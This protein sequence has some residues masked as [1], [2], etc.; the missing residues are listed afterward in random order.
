MKIAPPAFYSAKYILF[1]H[2][3]LKRQTREG[4]QKRGASCNF[5]KIIFD[6][7]FA[8]E[9]LMGVIKKVNTNEF[10]LL[11]AEHSFGRNVSLVNTFLP[12]TDISKLHA[13]IFF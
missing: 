8:I 2:L 13:L 7:L 3:F 4:L 11:N 12:G 9:L 1:L 10:V 6:L 5:Y